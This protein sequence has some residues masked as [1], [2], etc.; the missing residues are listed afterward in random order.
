M[1]KEEINKQLNKALKNEDYEKAAK[2][3]DLLQEIN[4]A[5]IIEIKDIED[6]IECRKKIVKSI[7]F[8]LKKYEEFPAL[9]AAKILS[10]I[11]TKETCI[12]ISTMSIELSEELFR[13]EDDKK[14]TGEHCCKIHE[15]AMA[16]ILKH[17]MLLEIKHNYTKK[18][19]IKADPDF[20][21]KMLI[22]LM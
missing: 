5:N 6:T 16:L 20:M 17:C 11:G 18:D 8:Y 2:L 10:T 22:N 12:F 3:R 4:E 14:F 19:S 13:I 9:L 1:N 7:D 15:R 21:E